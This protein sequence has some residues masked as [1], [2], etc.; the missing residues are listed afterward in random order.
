MNYNNWVPLIFKVS[1]KLW[2]IYFLM[3]GLREERESC[4]IPMIER[5]LLLIL[6]LITKTVDSGVK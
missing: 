4:R 1:K 3:L 2:L 6:I 5:K